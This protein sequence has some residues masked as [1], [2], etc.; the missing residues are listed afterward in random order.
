MAFAHERAQRAQQRRVGKLAVGLRDPVAAQDQRRAAVLGGQP[1]LQLGDQSG[2]AD[3]G[4][5]AEQ[6]ERG[7]T[8]A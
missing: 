6:D 3:A 2:L 4:V 1:L 8:G 7:P 5:T